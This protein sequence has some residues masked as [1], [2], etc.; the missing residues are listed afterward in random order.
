MTFKRVRAQLPV[1][2]WLGYVGLSCVLLAVVLI[3]AIG[4]RVSFV[5]AFLLLCWVICI[6]AVATRCEIC[7]FIWWSQK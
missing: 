7:V 6:H 2:Y 5:T 4:G 1:S 3:S